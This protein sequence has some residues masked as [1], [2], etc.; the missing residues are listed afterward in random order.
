MEKGKGK[1]LPS[2]DKASG[3]RP[4]SP[5]S[6]RSARGKG[7]S[8]SKGSSKSG[9]DS[10]QPSSRS[11]KA[12]PKSP[13]KAPSAEDSGRDETSDPLP[14]AERDPLESV[15]EGPKNAPEELEEEP[16]AQ[17]AEEAAEEPSE[18]TVEALVETAAEDLAAD[19]DFLSHVASVHRS[20]ALA[21]AEEAS[22]FSTEDMPEESSAPAA[23]DPG[24]L[25]WPS[26]ALA[27]PAEALQAFEAAAAMADAEPTKVASVPLGD[28][29]GWGLSL[30]AERIP[31][32]HTTTTPPPQLGTAEKEA[33][34]EEEEDD[35][36]DDDEEEHEGNVWCSLPIEDGTLL[37]A[38]TFAQRCV[39][40]SAARLRLLIALVL[41]S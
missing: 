27:A 39:L 8:S 38:G 35:D 25:M 30:E 6:Q 34:E 18:R 22:Q 21:A 23:V 29:G 37:D 26:V 36:A 16:S 40:L 32:P 1:K 20:L 33:T 41:T 3:S 11:V 17:A 28:N 2:L 15:S 19:G 9:V 12:K 14:D 4:K 7:Q 13:A 10:K 31:T 5:E 24:L